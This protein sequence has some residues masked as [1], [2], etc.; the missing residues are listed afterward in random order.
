MP[1]VSPRP[2]VVAAL[3]ATILLWASAFV[4][5]REALPSLGYDGLASGRLALAA[6]AFGA[7]A[8]VARVRRPR[9]SE[10]PALAA[11][12]ATGYAGYQLLLSAGEQTVPAGTAALLLS[13][14][15]VLSAVLAGPLLGERLAGRG[16]AGLLVAL[17][18]AAL[19][20]LSHRGEHGAGI[21]GALLVAAAAAVYAL[22]I[23]LQKRALRT[24]S[25]LHATMWATWFGALFALPFAHD[26]PASLGDASQR[27]ITA[28]LVLGLGLSTVPFLLWAWA[29]Q[30]L[31]A[32]VAAPALLMI[33]PAGVVLGWLL[34]GEQPAPL[35]VAGGA[36]TLAGVAAVQLRGPLRLPRVRVAPVVRESAPQHA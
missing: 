33:G 15:P 7:I 8:L 28:L 10:L 5:I 20:A 24:M 1:A 2:L 12:G 22:W 23:V 6:V 32:S 9:R 21:G 27:G 16:W 3:A 34:L 14:A 25:P 29:L 19:V 30:R 18:G 31:P 13:I 26:L 4:A 36:I 17:G 35:A 11:M